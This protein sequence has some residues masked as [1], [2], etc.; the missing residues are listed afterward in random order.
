ML[1]NVWSDPND[2]HP[3]EADS[4]D[5]AIKIGRSTIDPDIS[6]A[7]PMTKKDARDIIRDAYEHFCTIWRVDHPLPLPC[8]E[9]ELA[10]YLDRQDAYINAEIFRTIPESIRLFAI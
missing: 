8:T 3:V 2:K 5:E 10:S 9:T 6:S 7:Q 4:L 1:W